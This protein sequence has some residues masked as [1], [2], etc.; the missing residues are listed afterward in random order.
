MTGDISGDLLYEKSILAME[1]DPFMD[2]L[3][4]E[5]FSIA[6]LNY[7]QTPR[8]AHTLLVL[9]RSTRVLGNIKVPPPLNFTFILH[10]LKIFNKSLIL[11]PPL[12]FYIHWRFQ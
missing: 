4:I 7:A 11:P 10:S 1:H 2:D 6:L 3:P 5:M 12:N 9:G 8:F